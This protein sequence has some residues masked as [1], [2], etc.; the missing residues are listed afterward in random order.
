MLQNLQLLDMVVQEC[1]AGCD[2][3]RAGFTPE[4]TFSSMRN[5]LSMSEQ[6]KLLFLFPSLI[7]EIWVSL[8]LADLGPWRPYVLIIPCPNGSQ[9]P[10]KPLHPRP[11]RTCFQ[12]AAVLAAVQKIGW[13]IS[14]NRSQPWRCWRSLL[15]QNEP[16][17]SSINI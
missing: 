13:P 17:T 11:E 12:L 5:I 4:T 8:C 16:P 1:N 7:P 3:L 10:G 15:S 14:S 9:T 6:T 2:I